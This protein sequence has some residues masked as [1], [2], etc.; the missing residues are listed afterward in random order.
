MN[1]IQYF[2]RKHPLLVLFVIT[3]IALLL[4]AVTV[5]SA[6][7]QTAAVT[8]PVSQSASDASMLGIGAGLAVGLAGVGAGI[9]LSRS[10]AAAISALAEK[11]ETFF[12]AFLVVA[13]CEA[14]AIYGVVIAILLW[15]KIV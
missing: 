1:K 15:I 6:A 8:V 13:L 3:P 4:T 11:P 7:A 5:V 10:G 12:K 9:G 2:I 14:V